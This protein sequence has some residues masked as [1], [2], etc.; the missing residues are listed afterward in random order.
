M[1]EIKLTDAQLTKAL[2]CCTK[3]PGDL[4]GCRSC[5]LEKHWEDADGV[6][7]YD[8]LVL[9]AAARLEELVEENRRMRDATEGYAAELARQMTDMARE[10]NTAQERGLPKASGDDVLALNQIQARLLELGRVS[11]VRAVPGEGGTGWTVLGIS[12]E[13]RVVF[14]EMGGDSAENG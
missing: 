6:K 9:Q 1:E 5:T 4:D 12:V 14:G 2:R 13:D 8:R 3:D 7:C 11:V 10:C